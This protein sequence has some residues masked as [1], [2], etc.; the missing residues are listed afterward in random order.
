MRPV[1]KKVTARR[2]VFA[3]VMVLGGVIV[4]ERYFVSS[5]PLPRP[6]AILQGRPS[7]T[8]RQQTGHGRCKHTTRDFD[9]AFG[10]ASAALTTP[11]G[12]RHH[13]RGRE[14]IHTQSG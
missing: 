4:Q 11:L 14:G 8:R 9:P 6:L 12:S 1:S 7:R 5:S 2:A 10:W 13:L 3:A